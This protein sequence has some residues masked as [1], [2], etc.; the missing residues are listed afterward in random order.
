MYPRSGFWYRWSVFCTLVLA[1]GGPRNICQNHPLKFWNPPF[2]EPPIFGGWDKE[3]SKQHGGLICIHLQCWEVL[4]FLACQCQRCIKLRVLRAQ[5]FCI[6]LTL[7]R[8]QGQHWRCMQSSLP[9]KRRKRE[10]N[11]KRRKER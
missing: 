1:F 10:R 7:Q 8:K 2:C 9:L 4:P 11:G 5:D 6:M 3:K